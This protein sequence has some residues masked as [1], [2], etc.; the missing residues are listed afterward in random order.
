MS[1]TKQEIKL[2]RSEAR[3]QAF[4]LLF[5]RSFVQEPLEDTLADAEELFEGGVC[6]Y[7]RVVVMGIEAVQDEIDADIARFLKKGWSL[8]RIS[9]TSLTILRLA[10]YEIKFLDSIPDSVS[11]NEAVELAKKY[12]IDESGFVNGILGAFIRS[13]EGAAQ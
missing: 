3:E 13:R 6:D 1:D 4:M 5:S 7:A 10:V 8:S 9:R 2:S 12:T 11:V